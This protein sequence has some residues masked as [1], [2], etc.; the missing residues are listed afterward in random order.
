MDASPP[1]Q[2][3]IPDSEVKQ[4]QGRVVIWEAAPGL[5]DLAQTTVQRLDRVGGVDHLA[6]AGSKGEE[7][8]DVLPAASPGLADRRVALA[9]FVFELLEPKHC[10]FRILGAVDRL[11]RRQDCLAVLPCHE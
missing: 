4:L 5:D 2:A 1:P 8:N 9:P 3:G 6:D 10:H 11:D 7:R